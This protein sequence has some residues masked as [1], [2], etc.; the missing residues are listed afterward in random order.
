MR[1]NAPYRRKTSNSATISACRECLQE[2]GDGVGGHGLGPGQGFRGKW[3]LNVRN[4]TIRSDPKDRQLRGVP[5]V[6]PPNG[7]CSVFSD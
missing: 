2:I 4:G 6:D 5:L 3:R 7:L 1:N